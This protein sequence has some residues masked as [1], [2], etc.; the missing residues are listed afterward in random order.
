M[1]L[2]E[3]SLKGVTR[4]KKQVSLDLSRASG[5]IALVGRNGAGKTT[6][7]EAVV[8]SLFRSM[9]TRPGSIY[10]HCSGTDAFIS[11]TWDRQGL[12]VRSTIR[13]DAESRKVDCV[14]H[15]E[16]RESVTGAKAHEAAVRSTVGSKDLVLAGPFAAQSKAGQFLLLPVSKRK[17]LLAEMLGLGRL[18]E[19][20]GV[21]K[22]K[23]TGVT[24]ALESVRGAMVTLKERL[25]ARP[26]L[27][28]EL[29]RA[30]ADADKLREEKER[31]TRLAEAAA[32]DVEALKDRK[33]VI[34]L[35]QQAITAKERELV[36]CT[37][38]HSGARDALASFRQ[39]IENQVAV[40]RSQRDDQLQGI[41]A[42]GEDLNS[43]QD[44]LRGQMEKT[45]A[46]LANLPES[47]SN[48]GMDLDSTNGRLAQL[49]DDIRAL[50]D[51][52]CTKLELEHELKLAD[53]LLSQATSTFQGKQ[54]RLRETA[55]LRDKVPCTQAR[56]WSEAIIVDE[57]GVTPDT[58][59][60]LVPPTP[61]SAECPLLK[62]ANDAH[63][64]LV[65][66][67]LTE[68][69]RTEQEAHDH[70]QGRLQEHQSH[71]PEFDATRKEMLAEQEL[72]EGRVTELTAKLAS[73][74]ELL[75]KAEAFHREFQRQLDSAQQ[76]HDDKVAH[77]KQKATEAGEQERSLLESAQPRLAHLVEDLNQKRQTLKAVETDLAETK[78]ELERQ[79]AG[80]PDEDPGAIHAALLSRVTATEDRLSTARS[81]QAALGGKLEG[82]REDEQKLHEL[83]AQERHLQRDLAD[84]HLLMQALGKDGIQALEMDAAGPGI[85]ALCNA[86]LQECYGSRFS[87]GFDTLKT[88]KTGETR[89]SFQVQVYD[90]GVP[91]QAEMLSGG[92]KVIVS[93]AI[94]LAV[95]IFNAQRSGTRWE[96][97]FRDE[98]ASALDPEN[99]AAYV[100][101]LRR[102]L[103]L[104][105]FRQ[106]IYVAHLPA[107]WEAADHK[108]EVAD[109]QV[110]VMP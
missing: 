71:R 74:Q 30:N 4:F 79:Q 105:G 21:A 8:A 89:E 96:V 34:E 40:F 5:L 55:T 99:A 36:T 1:R 69:I 6:L 45:D 25:E 17:D 33:H 109:G 41:V 104:G 46:H 108:L 63:S 39:S 62:A 91:R 48:L 54:R 110:R 64:E 97:L 50:D 75:K 70:I 13:I 95:S 24:M 87:V 56:L 78:A 84:W 31:D 106:V 102:A 10:D 83:L 93:E 26:D 86:L 82:L 94:G 81:V 12:G 66:M 19:L 61:L 65:G 72:L 42:A 7:M 2:L 73:E 107:V 76:S 18:Q 47:I 92:E 9:V 100:A 23:Q 15:P 60:A 53:Q 27:E 57:P 32:R 68:A 20:H 51:W 35:Q 37:A 103:T 88:L 80:L 28:Q 85:A 98:T 22:T 59:G 49:R 58:I 67:D 29:T 43:A 90:Q 52:N 3:L 16:G 38:S 14:W 44:H 77:C 101:M 11:S